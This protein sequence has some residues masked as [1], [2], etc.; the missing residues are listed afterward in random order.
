MTRQPIYTRS[1][2]IA[3]VTLLIGGGVVSGSIAP[4]GQSVHY[5]ILGGAGLGL[6][7]QGSGIQTVTPPVI[8][9]SDTPQMGTD[10]TSMSPPIAKAMVISLQTNTPTNTPT[11][12]TDTAADAGILG[13]LV[14]GWV[15]TEAVTRAGGLESMKLPL[16]SSYADSVA[17]PTEVFVTEF[18]F[19]TGA[20]AASF[21]KQLDYAGIGSGTVVNGLSNTEGDVTQ[22]ASNVPG[23]TVFNVQWVSGSFVVNASIWGGANLTASQAVDTVFPASTLGGSSASGIEANGILAGPTQTN[24][25]Y[26]DVASLPWSAM[27]LH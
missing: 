20:V 26:A 10:W 27:G 19:A 18:Q 13:T 24:P 17:G 14:E 7:S 6:V 1:L 15:L 3:V 9:S 11:N 21:F 16:S 23:E 4:G 2:A 5:R 22:V 8:A 12:V 25:I